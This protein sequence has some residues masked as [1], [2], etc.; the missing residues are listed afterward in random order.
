MKQSHRFLP[1]I[2]LI[3]L[4][5][6]TLWASCRTYSV[7][8]YVNVSDVVAVGTVTTTRTLDPPPKTRYDSQSQQVTCK[9]ARSDHLL[10]VKGP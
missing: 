6:Q 3:L 2:S 9:K 7:E 10:F 5:Q 8:W 1:C 4:A